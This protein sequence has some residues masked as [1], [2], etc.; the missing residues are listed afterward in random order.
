MADKEDLVLGAVGGLGWTDI[1][2][3][4]HSLSL[5]GFTGI[6]AMIVYDDGK[7]VADNLR[8]MGFQVIEMP[9][10]GSVWN[11][12]FY[13]IYEVIRGA[14]DNLRYCVVTD[15]RDVYFQADPMA[16]LEAKL[17]KAFV[18]ASEG[19]LYRDE[20][21]NRDN[22]TLSFPDLAARLQD[23]CVYNVGV[24]AGEARAVADIALAV[25]LIAR[26]SG[27][28]IAD[29]SAYNLL[30]DMEPYRSACQFGL[31]EDGL[32]CQ[33]GTFVSPY[34]TALR[35]YLLEPLPLFDGELITTAA[36]IPYAMVHQYDRVQPWHDAVRARLNRLIAERGA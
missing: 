4:A 21:W 31:S 23:R 33:A 32:V 13:D 5:S 30:L 35:P 25:G 17:T 2:V 20:K 7:L 36:G 24:L 14:G 15:V 11:Q 1:E 18:A 22:L 9:L 10:R 26:S 6:K 12:R 3:W 16:W 8:A 29:Q 19:I 34:T 28:N 27:A